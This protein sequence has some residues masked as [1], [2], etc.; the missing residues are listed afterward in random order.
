MAAHDSLTGL[1]NR[2]ILMES[3]TN[4]LLSRRS[5]EREVAVL[6]FDLDDF[7]PI[8]DTLGHDAGDRV[9]VEVGNRLARSAREGDLVARFAGDEFVVLVRGVASADEAET[10]AA[11]LVAAVRVPIPVA[12]RTVVVSASVGIAFPGEHDSA[13]D[14]LRAADRDMYEAKRRNRLAAMIDR[15]VAS[16][17]GVRAHAH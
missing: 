5:R 10:A 17:A 8:N 13:A 16:A 1:V 11:R 9:L 14:A 12:G 4:A 7:K 3:L 6:F 2:R 15:P